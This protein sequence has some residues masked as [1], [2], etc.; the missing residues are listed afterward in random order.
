M[1]VASKLNLYDHHH[2]HQNNSNNEDINR[3]NKIIR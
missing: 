3:A 2:H 1:S